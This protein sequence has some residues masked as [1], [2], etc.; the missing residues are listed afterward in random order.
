M[1]L[2]TSYNI[3]TELKTAK[4]NQFSA[5]LSLK[6]TSC[7]GYQTHL[8]LFRLILPCGLVEGRSSDLAPL[9]LIG[10][11]HIL[12]MLIVNIDEKSNLYFSFEFS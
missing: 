6:K 2:C 1:A 5:V 8:E 4:L 11:S 10:R 9:L 7:R 12:T 3:C